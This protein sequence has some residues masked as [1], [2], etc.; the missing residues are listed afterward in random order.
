MAA[1]PLQKMDTLSP[2]IMFDS[3]IYRYPRLLRMKKR[4][5]EKRTISDNKNV[6]FITI[7]DGI[8]T[9]FSMQY[10]MKEQYARHL[11]NK[12]NLILPTDVIYS[13]NYSKRLCIY[14]DQEL[15][16]DELSLCD[17]YYETDAVPYPIIGLSEIT[18]CL[19]YDKKSSPPLSNF[20]MIDTTAAAAATATAATQRIST[21]TGFVEYRYFEDRHSVTNRLWLDKVG[22]VVPLVL[23]RAPSPIAPR[24]VLVLSDNFVCLDDYTGYWYFDNEKLLIHLSVNKNIATITSAKKATN[25]ELRNKTN[26]I[27]PEN[28]NHLT[29]IVTSFIRQK[30]NIFNI[31]VNKRNIKAFDTYVTISVGA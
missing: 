6:I 29:N 18:S 30:L 8:L 11:L 17:S 20:Y 23:E 19:S 4:I 14:S 12:K 1:T 16:P 28:D 15:S 21:L 27:L 22:A 10:I 31:S 26:R 7:A 9:G 3:Y 2:R 13:S 24:L 5:L 25:E